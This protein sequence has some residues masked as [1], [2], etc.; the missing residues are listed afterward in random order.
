[1][2]KM[3]IKIP[4]T[5]PNDDKKKK[6]KMKESEGFRPGGSEKKSS[7]SKMKDFFD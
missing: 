6:K 5:L 2:D 3:S 4:K 7:F 1:M